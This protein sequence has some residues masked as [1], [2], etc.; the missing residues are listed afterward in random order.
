MSE[1]A[2]NTAVDPAED[3]GF[4][5]VVATIFDTLLNAIHDGRMLPGE[6]ISD[7]ALAAEFKVSRTPVREALQRLRDLGLVEAVAGRYTRVAVVSPQQTAQAMIVW[8]ALYSALVDEVIADAPEEIF[9]AMSRDH[10]AYLDQLAGRD[11]RKIAT[12]NFSFYE[13]LM[14]LS[15]NPI[16]VSGITHVVHLIRLG[17]LHLPDSIDIT[18]LADAQTRLLAAVANHDARLAR[19][20]IQVI[21]A[22]EVPQ[23]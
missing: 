12:H 16:L 2:P 1:V 11:F 19:E 15:D 4:S 17:S 6:R 22:I 5:P 20:A 3:I 8:I 18:A 9:A 21:R 13:H 7:G 10:A 23:E 14:P